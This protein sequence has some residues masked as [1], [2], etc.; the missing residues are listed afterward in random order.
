[1]RALRAVGVARSAP[2]PETAGAVRGGRL[3]DDP[4]RSR[5]AAT[6]C[7][8]SLF[9]GHGSRAAT[10]VRESCRRGAQPFGLG[11][12]RGDVPV[13]LDD[14]DP[15]RAR[16]AAARRVGCFEP[17]G[18]TSSTSTAGRCDA[19]QMRRRARLFSPSRSAWQPGHR[20]AP[21]LR[22]ASR[23]RDVHRD[24][25]QWWSQD[26]RRRWRPF[27]LHTCFLNEWRDGCV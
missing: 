4:Q 20:S 18:G 15:G 3:H 1:M 24:E 25:G 21:A 26:G 8:E 9:A 19:R 2:A 6:C 12:A 27:E 5:T 10:D 11:Y 13:S 16:A 23:H 22:A 17:L 7:T 14:A